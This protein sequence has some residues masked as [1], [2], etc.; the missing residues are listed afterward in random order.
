MPSLQSPAPPH[1]QPAKQPLAV[2]THSAPPRPHTPRAPSYG[3]LVPYTVE[4]FAALALART[5]GG[6]GYA[7]STFHRIV[8]GFMIPVR[9]RGGGVCVCGGV[10]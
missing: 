3:D 7:G 9:G 10:C 1:C 6:V 4:N 8:E 5:P 2:L